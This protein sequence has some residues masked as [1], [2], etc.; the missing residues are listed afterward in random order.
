MEW[1]LIANT[2]LQFKTIELTLEKKAEKKQLSIGYWEEDDGNYTLAILDIDPQT[3]KWIDILTAE[4]E[5]Y[6]PEEVID[7]V[8]K[9][10]IEL[11]EGVWLPIPIFAKKI[12]PEKGKLQFNEGPLGWCRGRLDRIPGQDGKYNLILL[13]NTAIR[14]DLSQEVHLTLTSND[15]D[16]HFQ[17]VSDFFEI[18]PLLKQ[19][20]FDKSLAKIVEERK[21][22]AGF[23][24]FESSNP[25]L[26]QGA[27]ILFLQ[28]LEEMA[29]IPTIAVFQGEETEPSIGVNLILDIGN[30]R[31]TGLLIEEREE[32]G[33]ID[34]S[35]SYPLEIRDLEFPYKVTQKPFPMRCEF[36]NTQFGEFEIP[37]WEE[38]FKW[39][40]L[41][42]IG[43]EADRLSRKKIKTFLKTGLS[44]PKRYLWDDNRAVE[45]WYFSNQEGI[46]SSDNSLLK[47]VNIDY[48]GR[49]ADIEQGT[50]NEMDGKF[51]RRALMV[52]AIIELLMQ[53]LVTI[54]SHNF[55]SRHGKLTR[56]RILRRLVLTSPTAMAT[57]EKRIFL[58]AG[59][60]A[61]KIVQQYF[62]KVDPNNQTISQME[63]IP[64]KEDIVVDLRELEQQER[65]GISKEWG[66]DE[67]TSL[68][69][70]FIY[71]EIMNRYQRE[72]GLFFELEGRNRPIP[73]EELSTILS[74]DIKNALKKGKAV[75]IASL[76]IG[77]GTSDL[78]ICS[79]RNLSLTSGVHLVPYPEFYEGFSIA[80]DDLLKRIVERVILHNIRRNLE[81]QTG[82]KE[83][84]KFVDHLFGIASSTYSDMDK[85]FK[86]EFSYQIAQPLA[87]YGL[88]LLE[89]GESEIIGKKLVEIF[90]ELGVNSPNPN[91]INYINLR[92]KKLLG[93]DY[94]FEE[95]LYI[96]HPREIAHT[97]EQTFKNELQ[98]L[99][100][101]I[102]QLKCDYLVLGG[103]LSSIYTLRQIFHKYLPLPP[104]R[105]ITLDNYPIGKWYPFASWD[106]RV[107]DPK[108]S[109]VVGASIALIA[110]TLNRLSGFNL[111]THF[112]KRRIKSTA[113]YIGE[114]DRKNHILKKIWF[115][116]NSNIATE[117]NG[118][119]GVYFETPVLIGKS[120]FKVLERGPGREMINNWPAN[121]LYSIGYSSDKEVSRFISQRPFKIYLR[122][123]PSNY[124]LIGIKNGD[125]L[126]PLK[127]ENRSGR[128]IPNTILEIK[129]KTIFGEKGYWLDTG[130]FQYTGDG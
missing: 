56:R 106:G 87:L 130:E 39:G 98:R 84:A 127:I 78:M 57:L 109:V 19:E 100:Q 34:F 29:Q 59:E 107:E 13:F 52:F 4:K 86:R 69:L 82:T 24:D 12:N 49:I 54:N 44:S 85:E 21:E 102:E 20:W 89:K 30:A 74:S 64:K 118:E 3:G 16:C 113:N 61:V 26:H 75:T 81:E 83:A 72:G 90:D 116:E 51:S 123:H 32:E 8:G 18:V 62:S 114:L 96:Y 93:V 66:F 99:S 36:A 2:G 92:A 77:G 111:N 38:S 11:F 33:D 128:P 65:P 119:E 122:R 27:Y 103:R 95:N 45:P 80:G 35:Y 46:V 37:G 125:V 101:I 117:P 63:I 10:V 94:R 31:T 120:Q 91:L 129:L 28:I 14:N 48:K 71:G 50:F 41:L 22:R 42:R 79:Y 112:L 5:E 108:T 115:N 9:K 126:N 1:S 40:S 15:K 121:P 23:S 124:E 76:D 73:E 104:A 53:G 6:P 17:L 70:A 60:E 58:E 110:G 47:Y 105:I 88:Q 55:R 68:Q 43:E 25:L 97:L 67:A 7:L